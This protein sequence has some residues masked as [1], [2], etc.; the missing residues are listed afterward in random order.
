MNDLI[1]ITGNQAK[2]DYLKKW[3]GHPVEH[4]KMDLDEI[5][6][7]DPREVIEHKA[8]SAY[9]IIGRPVL[10]EDVGLSF[11][12]FGGK[13][14]GTLIKW[15]LTEVGSAGLLKMLDGYT[16]RSAH[17][18]IAYGLYDG[19]SLHVFEG[20]TDGSIALEQRSSDTDGWHG[21]LSWNSIFIPDGATK[22]YAEMTDDELLPF[23]HRAKAI[24]KLRDFLDQ[25]SKH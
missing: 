11:D 1:F 10:V 22:T 8:R 4:Q 13:L 21:S 17:T 14:P 16:D 18:T 19:N 20:R 7:L 24:T 25:Q 15:F 9:E 6:S 23:S 2:A 5:Q 12:A 3:L